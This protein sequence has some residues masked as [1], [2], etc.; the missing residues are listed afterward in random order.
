M[1]EFCNIIQLYLV[2]DIQSFR[3]G[4]IT[5]KSGRSFA[6]LQT[7]DF[8]VTPKEEKSDA[9]T[10]YNIEE[11]INIEKAPTSVTSTYSIRRSAIVRLSTTPG[12][13]PVYIGSIAWPAQVSIVTNLNKDTLQVKAKMRQSPL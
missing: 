9:G 7:E 2:Q 5:M 11:N 8:S 13:N 4:I 1:K 10:L 3:D 12:D 6:E